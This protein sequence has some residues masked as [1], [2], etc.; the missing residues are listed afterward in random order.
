MVSFFHQATPIRLNTEYLKA[1]SLN[2]S[3]NLK[4]NSKKIGNESSSIWGRI[5]KIVRGRKSCAALPYPNI[6]LNLKTS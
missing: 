2:I 4:P 1:G 3:V 5:M 6:L